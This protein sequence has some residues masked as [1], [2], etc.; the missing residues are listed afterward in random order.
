[1]HEMDDAKYEIIDLMTVILDKKQTARNAVEYLARCRD[2]PKPED[3]AFVLDVPMSTAMKIVAAAR[4]STKFVF[5]TKGVSLTNPELVAAYLSDLKDKAVEHLVALTLNS[6]NA[7]IKRH[8]IAT[9]SAGSVCVNYG[10]V[11]RCAIEDRALGLIVAHNHPSGN[12]KFSENDYLFSEGLAETGRLLN[13]RFLD[14]MVISRRGF[15]SMR[16]ERPDI[17]VQT[18]RVGVRAKLAGEQ[19]RFSR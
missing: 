19:G 10:D 8:L 3:V 11:F 2:I 4:M 14:S 17:F 16:R 6:E 15:V 5:G 1:M 12:L 9:G 13:I 18:A 7:L